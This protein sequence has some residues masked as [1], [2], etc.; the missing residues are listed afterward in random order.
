MGANAAS[1]KPGSRRRVAVV[2]V[3]LLVLLDVGR[4]VYSRIGFA[5]PTE[6][7]E[8]DPKVYANLTWPPGADTPP[9]ATPGARLYAQHCATCHGPD[10]RGNGPAAPSQI[11]RPR[12]FTRGAFKFKST[13]F[14]E[15]P[16]DADLERVIA[17]GLQASAMPYFRD[18]LS[19]PDIRALVVHIKGMSDRF[20]TPPHPIA[21][22]DPP[23]TAGGAERG[24]T[25]YRSLA[26]DTCHGSDGRK[27]SVIKDAKGYPTIA[28]DLT[29]PWTFAGGSDPAQVW[30]RLTTGMKPG[31]MPS[32][33]DRTSAEERW[34]LVQF[35]AS[36]ARRAPWEPGGT[37]D[38][39]GHSADL[40]KR[41][42]YF[43]RAGMC[44]L[45]HTQFNSTGIYRSDEAY[46][47]GG[48][49]GI[50]YPHG[51]FVTS[52][53][54]PDPATG[55][56][57]WSDEQIAAATR[58]GRAPARM[59]TLWTMPWHFLHE[60]TAEDALAIAKYL[61]TTLPAVDNRIPRPLHQ[62]FIETIAVK[63]TRPFPAADPEFASF[64]QGNFGQPRDAWSR[65][66]PQQLLV[67]AQAVVAIAGVVLFVFAAPPGERL[68]ADPQ[69]RRR[70]IMRTV[71]AIAGAGGAWGLYTRP[72]SAIIPAGTIAAIGTKGVPV[73]D[74]ESLRDPR[75]AAL[76]AR[77]RY[78]YIVSS[79]AMCHENDGRGGR[80]LS[81]KPFGTLYFSNITTD[82]D[83]GI[84]RWTDRE[85]ARAIRSGVSR[86]GRA[87]HW[88]A[89]TWDFLSNY[90]EE[91]IRALIV[92][93]RTL[94]PVRLAIPPPRPPAD[95]DCAV[96]SFWIAR[97]TRPGCR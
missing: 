20:A 70:A 29:A 84:G 54:T 91:D 46:L 89:M 80:K 44:G 19:D 71:A 67:G 73:P 41:G 32:Y 9:T 17:D 66:L 53:L 81:W 10:G 16:S 87:L 15:P 43:V 85:I 62:G 83:T 93:L 1:R 33:A 58:E 13:P 36:I 95:D 61:K 11:P 42:E 74:P 78:L 69:R 68:P 37:L 39:A 48:Q 6:Y 49:R 75:Q 60:Y 92:Y 7:W 47:A 59:L 21:V 57:G 27:R 28:T 94:P 55:V 26:C 52:N 56:G 38:G 76:A 77:G 30:L 82:A 97:T 72:T 50:A 35:I 63:L 51:V 5:A 96:Y 25:L 23:K 2:T 86:N 14:D 12:D 45:C 40:A 79:C 3:S 4:S 22:P 8:P 88:Q 34:D 31:P 24:G 90:D 18:I 65:T 64:E